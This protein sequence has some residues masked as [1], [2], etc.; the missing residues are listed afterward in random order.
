MFL[1]TRLFSSAALGR[2][3]GFAVVQGASLSPVGRPWEA[4]P[5]PCARA[6]TRVPGAVR[7][8]H[9]HRHPRSSWNRPRV[10][11]WRLS[12]SKFRSGLQA[13]TVAGTPGGRGWIQT[14]SVSCGRPV[15]QPVPLETVRDAFWPRAALTLCPGGQRRRHLR[16]TAE[17]TGS[18]RPDS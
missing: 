7:S 13:P 4:L 6:F 8:L 2:E 5:S 9:P 10:S 3:Q 16:V 11:D 1:V 18:S 12:L 14:R 15:P 17:E